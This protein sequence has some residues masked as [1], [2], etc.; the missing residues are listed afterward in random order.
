MNSDIA[1]GKWKQLKG[2]IQ[3]KWG[4]LTDDD[5][6]RINGNR[7]KFIGVMQEKYGVGKQQAEK[8][9]DDFT[10]QNA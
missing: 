4:Q 1:E 9:F 5:I 8:E 6:D 7:Q 2:N 10:A 3:Q